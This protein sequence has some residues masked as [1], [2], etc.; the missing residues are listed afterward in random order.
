M[1]R[2]L[3]ATY[4]VLAAMVLV[5]L[6]VPL[7]I[8][9]Q[10]SLRHGL[11]QR[12]ERDAV[13]L[14]ALVEDG[15]QEGGA[16]RR[17]V[18][19]GVIDRYG[20]DTGVRV[21]VVDG[22]GRLVADSEPE[23]GLG[24]DFATRPEIARALA[25]EV[26]GGERYS[27]TLGQNLLFVTVPVTSGGRV[28][29]AV[30]ASVPTTRIDAATWRY[31]GLLALIAAMVLA[32]TAL[33]GRWLAGWV[34]R[35][36]EALRGSARR[37][38]AGDLGERARVDEGPP[39]VRELA[40]A[41]N[42]MVSRLSRLVGAQEQFVADA[43]HQLR[44]P[45]TALRLRI[46]NLQY[47]VTPDG[48]DDVDAAIGEVDRLT[49]LVNGLLT[50]ARADRRGRVHGERAVGPVVADRV[51][52]W[53]LVA[54]EGDVRLEAGDGHGLRADLSDG[55]LEQVLDNLIANALEVAP[56]GTAVTVTAEARGGHVM[57]AVCDRGPGMTAAARAHAFDRFWSDRPG[58]TGFGLG[59]A[60]VRRLVEADGGAVSLAEN[61]GGGLRAEVEYPRR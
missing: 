52:A 50:L 58:N 14:A 44:S 42:D 61:P 4:V 13:A 47:D 57:V 55:A 48:G 43:S 20:D 60:I 5:V 37:V 26:V 49:R 29:G 9:H 40:G 1:T 10:S 31:R 2:R 34:A 21:V 16:D 54:A 38:A 28:Y 6:E 51:D 18:L 24:R 53:R 15:L 41:F 32:A 19:T 12:V 23:R 33:A 7:A 59:L 11:Q 45:L 3:V 22:T 8:V 30:R 46:E 35:P 25:G 36:L 27:D 39:E 56:A 17:R